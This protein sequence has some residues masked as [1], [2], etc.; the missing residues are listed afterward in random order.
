MDNVV[1]DQKRI[2]EILP[3]DYP[4]IMIDRVIEFEKDKSLV[5]IKNITGN[6]WVFEGQAD[7]ADIFPETLII[8]AASQAALVFYSVNSTNAKGQIL[9]RI[10]L[11]GI[12]SEFL[13]TVYIGDQLRFTTRD[14][15]I[16][17][18]K[19]YI[20]VDVSRDGEDISRVKVFYGL[21]D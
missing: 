5:A 17:K 7:K 9:S 14:F 11:G 18:E 21:S 20:N 15:K 8:E 16:L 2:S 12:K 3:Q 6:E 19:G 1:L 4:F 10:R 13:Q